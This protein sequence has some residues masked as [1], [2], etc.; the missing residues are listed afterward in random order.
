MADWPDLSAAAKY[1]QDKLDGLIFSP[2]FL[3]KYLLLYENTRNVVAAWGQYRKKIFSWCKSKTLA[4]SLRVSDRHDLGFS[5]LQ[6][7]TVV[8]IS[9]ISASYLLR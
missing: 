9:A 3:E 4:L 1:L 6:S 8:E 2:V 7:V 5:L